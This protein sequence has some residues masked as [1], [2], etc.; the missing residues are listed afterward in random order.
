MESFVNKPDTIVGQPLKAGFH[1]ELHYD[2]DMDTLSTVLDGEKRVS[3]AFTP[4]SAFPFK[5]EVRFSIAHSKDCLFLKYYVE[6]KVAVAA[7]S[8]THSAVYKDS[9]V[10][11]FISFDTAGYYNFEFNCTGT[12]LAAY[13]KGRENRTF[14][15]IE[16]ID[17]IRRRA[18]IDKSGPSAGVKWTLT[19]AIPLYVFTAHSIDS[20][21][22]REC[23]AN[24]YKCGED[25]PDP[26][27]LAWANIDSPEP[28]FHLPEHFG[29]L[30]FE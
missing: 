5:P 29:S 3:L 10:E 12:A 14:L 18:V 8:D 4:W 11:F 6:E 16:A 21:S 30:I 27:F 28:D 23:R 13:G 26:H 25:L 22:G 9:C 2:A 20:L 1:E 19:L 17:R 24:F 7:H 15:S